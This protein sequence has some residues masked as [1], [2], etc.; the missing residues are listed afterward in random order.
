M[1]KIETVK[2][3]KQKPTN[4]VCI[5]PLVSN[6]WTS[7]NSGEYH[8]IQLTKAEVYRG[9]IWISAL[10]SKLINKLF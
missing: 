3:K 2:R 7:D 5:H 1:L 8:T 10:S 4:E 6:Y 9:R